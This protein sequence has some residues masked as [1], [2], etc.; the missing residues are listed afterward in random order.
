[1]ALSRTNAKKPRGVG[2]VNVLKVRKKL[3][4]ASA[5]RA[6]STRRVFEACTNVE[7]GSW[8]GVDRMTDLLRSYCRMGKEAKVGRS[9]RRG[10]I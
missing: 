7:K 4:A 2:C 3:S 9:E 5:N 10:E 6:Y 8:L 1:M